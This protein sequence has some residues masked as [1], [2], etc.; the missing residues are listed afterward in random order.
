MRN[1]QSIR[2]ELIVEENL[3]RIQQE[4]LEKVK[5][6]SRRKDDIAFKKLLVIAGFSNIL[7]LPLFYFYAPHYNPFSFILFSFVASGML[8]VFMMFAY[9]LF[10]SEPN[11]VIDVEGQNEKIDH[12]KK[13]RKLEFELLESTL[14]AKIIHVINDEL[15]KKWHNVILEIDGK[16]KEYYASFPRDDK[17]YASV[18][19]SLYLL[20][21]LL[22][23]RNNTP[24]KSRLKSL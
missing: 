20:N 11:L 5:K 16:A 7:F 21:N 10:F 15:D 22:K 2:E 24:L 13:V 19:M 23:N 4:N 17:G 6:E 18:D 8:F 9:T 12:L 14:G 1:V 3:Y